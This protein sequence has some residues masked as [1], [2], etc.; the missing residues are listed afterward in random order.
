VKEPNQIYV[1]FKHNTDAAVL[2]AV[3]MATIIIH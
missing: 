1:S 3:N 2:S